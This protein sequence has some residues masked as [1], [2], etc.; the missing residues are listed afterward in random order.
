MVCF[1]QH[2]A[3]HCCVS[4]ETETESGACFAHGNLCPIS[5]GGS[6]GLES[7]SIPALNWVPS[8]TDATSL[9]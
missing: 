9:L 3:A 7:C 8:G 4:V 5:P 1:A 2:Q 6:L